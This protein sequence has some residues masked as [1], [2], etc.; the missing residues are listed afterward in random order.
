[1]ASMKHFRTIANHRDDDPRKILK[2]FGDRNIFTMTR[3]VYLPMS[4]GICR[5]LPCRTDDFEDHYPINGV[6]I[7][8]TPTGR[9]L[10]I[11]HP[12]H[13][14]PCPKLKR[15]D[16]SPLS[17]CKIWFNH[18][19]EDANKL[20]KYLEQL[21][22]ELG[23][24]FKPI[25]KLAESLGFDLHNYG[26]SLAPDR[27]TL[28]R[29][30]FRQILNSEADISPC[31]RETFRFV[32]ETSLRDASLAKNLWPLRH[33]LSTIKTVHRGLSELISTLDTITK[34]IKDIIRWERDHAHK[35][36]FRMVQKGSP[37]FLDR[38]HAKGWYRKIQAF[39]EH[40]NAEWQAE[41]LGA[42]KAPSVHSDTSIVPG[43]VRKLSADT[44]NSLAVAN[45]RERRPDTHSDLARKASTGTLG[46]SAEGSRKNSSSSNGGHR[47]VPATNHGASA[48]GLRRMPSMTSC[49]AHHTSVHN[50]SLRAHR[51]A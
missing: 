9:R 43:L 33:A 1:M 47:A 26:L 20:Q 45:E 48:G 31:L 34:R 18:Y 10:L 29:N 41:Q 36:E 11:S 24:H 49:R 30:L 32:R 21:K 6:G 13:D 17:D 44:L 38:F 14:E 16:A 8:K 25:T 15:D 42:Q 3:E 22:L 51:R 2:A 27:H 46:R 7:Y 40:C 37:L 5:P 50:T 23:E 19:L 4:D 12:K 28:H 35:A 39:W